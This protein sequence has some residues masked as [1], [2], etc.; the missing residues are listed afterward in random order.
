[1]KV[2]TPNT[3]PQTPVK[4]GITWGFGVWHLAF[5]EERDDV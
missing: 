5:H 3:N 1:M 2:K 4:L